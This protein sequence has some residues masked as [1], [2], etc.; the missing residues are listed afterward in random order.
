LNDFLNCSLVDV[1]AITDHNDFRFHEIYSGGK[2][3]YKI[4]NKY[5][6]TGEEIMTS[7]AGEVIGLF[8][9][10][11]IKPYMT[12][13]ETIK[14]IK[15]QGGIVYIPHPYDFYRKGRPNLH[16]VKK[17]IDLVDFVEVFNAKYF[18]NIEVNLS[19]R[20]AN[21][22]K[23]LRG[24]GSDAHKVED[25]GKGVVLLRSDDIELSKEKIIELLSFEEN[26]LSVI[27]KR[28]NILKAVM[29][30]WRRYFV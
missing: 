23:K 16:I 19:Y 10:K 12:F 17:Y 4:E 15:N 7:D 5:F 6:I 14:E 21:I 18:T 25:L 9:N 29:N 22:Y 20:F 26:I 2:V 11:K 28:R 30:K 8:L 3:I 24:Y 13:E 1:F 27:Q